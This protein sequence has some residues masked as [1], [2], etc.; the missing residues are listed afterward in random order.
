VFSKTDAARFDAASPA[1]TDLLQL[2]AEINTVLDHL[3]SRLC[4]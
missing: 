4:N 2:R 3:E 1:T